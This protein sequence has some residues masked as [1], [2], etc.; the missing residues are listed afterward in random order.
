MPP[1]HSINMANIWLSIAV[2]KRFCLSYQICYWSLY[3]R[4]VLRYSVNSKTYWQQWYGL[5]G[6]WLILRFHLHIRFHV[7]VMS[8]K[9]EVYKLAKVHVG[10][11]NNVSSNCNTTLQ[12]RQSLLPRLSVYDTLYTSPHL[13]FRQ[14]SLWQALLYR[15]V[16]ENAT[17]H[18]Y[19]TQ[20]YC[21]HMSSRQVLYS[22]PDSCDR[23]SRWLA[24]S[25]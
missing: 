20:Y 2:L 12:T 13:S 7:H 23:S 15:R 18:L 4:S 22:R 5:P 1:V 16:H 8:I 24:C 11:N 10:E 6:I 3:K 21:Q 14:T 17:M 25:S 9:T 19:S